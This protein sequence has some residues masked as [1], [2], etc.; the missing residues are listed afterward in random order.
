MSSII[1][2]N[3]YSI[4]AQ[5]FSAHLVDKL[6]LPVLETKK[7]TR[8][9]RNWEAQIEVQNK[10]HEKSTLRSIVYWMCSLEMVYTSGGITII[11]VYFHH[12]YHLCISWPGIYTWQQKVLWVPLAQVTWSLWLPTYFSAFL[13]YLNYLFQICAPHKWFVV[14][15]PDHHLVYISRIYS[16]SVKITC[17]IFLY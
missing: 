14:N 4:S 12:H 16:K 10:H 3:L 9:P 11:Q 17:V 6:T 2:R 15:M 1:L 13:M 8:K 7:W 5:Y